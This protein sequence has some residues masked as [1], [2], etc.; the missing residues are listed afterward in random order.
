MDATKHFIIVYTIILSL[1]VCLGIGLNIK[2]IL[3][4]R[5]VKD[6]TWMID[7]THSIVLIIYFTTSFIL[8]ALTLSIQQ[9]LH[10]YSGRWLC[11]FSSLVIIYG[12]YS[13]VSHSLIISI[14]KYVFIV[15]N[16]MVQDVGSE[17]VKQIFFRVNLL[18]PLAMWLLQFVTHTNDYTGFNS[19]GRCYDVD[20]EARGN[21]T[22]KTTD[23]Y[24]FF[25]C[26]LDRNLVRE[27]PYLDIIIHISKLV[28]C[29]LSQITTSILSSNVCEGFFYFM[30]FRKMNRYV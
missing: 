6:F 1:I 13:I 9:P 12:L 3:H 21:S 4:F 15:K 14:M 27:G 26:E 8:D 23:N 24:I 18:L 16:T 11:D 22:L 5:K 30:I 25:F 7:I 29:L 17:K 2:A 19:L 28:F 20:L 10:L